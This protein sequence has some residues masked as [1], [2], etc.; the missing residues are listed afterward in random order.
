MILE[1]KNIQYVLTKSYGL[2]A[3]L[4]LQIS[5]LHEFGHGVGFIQ[6]PSELPQDASESLILF[7]IE[8]LKT[9]SRAQ[10]NK[11]VSH[12]DWPEG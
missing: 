2:P 5:S 4:Y 8:G 11:S 12:F 10:Y 1:I 9:S 3:Q 7:V 6:S